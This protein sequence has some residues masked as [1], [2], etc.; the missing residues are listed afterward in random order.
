MPVKFKE[1][2][3]GHCGIHGRNT[4]NILFMICSCV[5]ASVFLAIESDS[6]TRN[7]PLKQP[8]TFDNEL[9]FSYCFENKKQMYPIAADVNGASVK[10]ENQPKKPNQPTQTTKFKRRHLTL[11]SYKFKN[12]SV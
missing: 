5:I 10:D 12:Y 11:D 1:V 2:L 6:N 7:L 8:Y 9:K 3:C 4:R